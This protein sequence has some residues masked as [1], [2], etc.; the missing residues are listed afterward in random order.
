MAA[1]TQFYGSSTL[2]ARDAVPADAEQIAANLRENDRHEVLAVYE[3]VA[4]GIREAIQASAICHTLCRRDGRYQPM[5]VLGCATDPSRPG[6]GIPWL[7]AT[8]EVVKYP[9]ALTR[10]G[11]HY[12]RLFQERW[13]VLMN[14]VDERNAVSVAWLQRL[15]FAVHEPIVFGRNGECFHPFTLGV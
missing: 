7:L 9:G 2:V 13:P 3:N 12:V 5:I 6:V 11:R 14:Y 4:H 15:G 1:D 10:V 8:N